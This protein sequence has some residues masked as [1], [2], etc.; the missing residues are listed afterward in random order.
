MA[1]AAL[2]SPPSSKLSSAAPRAPGRPFRESRQGAA[3]K[4]GLNHAVVEHPG[5]VVV[6]TADADGQPAP[7]DIL[8]VASALTAA[9]DGHLIL[10]VRGFATDVP[11]R[12]RF[13]NSLTRRIMKIV[14]GQAISDTQTGL[15]GIPFGFIPALLRLDPNGYDFEL[16][17]LVTCR[18]SGITIQEVPIATIYL[19]GNRSSH[20]NPLRDSMRIYFI[21]AR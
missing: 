21:F 3:L 8:K 9:G 16:D 18:S 1:A 14:T 4:T 6:V 12:S 13:G 10:G 2:N 11:F 15:R 17:M 19:N 7:A 5:S 20:F